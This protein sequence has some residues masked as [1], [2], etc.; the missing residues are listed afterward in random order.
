MPRNNEDF[1]GGRATT[2]L[3]FNEGTSLN[4]A[5]RTVNAVSKKG[6]PVQ[7]GQLRDKIEVAKRYG[8]LDPMKSTLRSNGISWSTF[9]PHIATAFPDMTRNE[10]IRHA[11]DLHDNDPNKFHELISPLKKGQ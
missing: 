9:I 10:R 2:S 7:P 8:P 6:N 11:T 1:Q 4:V 5:G 3:T